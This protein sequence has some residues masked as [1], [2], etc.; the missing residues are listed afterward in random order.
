ME[1]TTKRIQGFRKYQEKKIQ[2]SEFFFGVVIK[3]L[4][5]Q[6]RQAK[7]WGLKKQ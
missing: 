2:V 4:S 7:M 1:Y 3:F 6:K 5:S